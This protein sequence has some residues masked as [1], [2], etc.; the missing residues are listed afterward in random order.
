MNIEF[1]SLD[2]A[3]GTTAFPWLN[4]GSDSR[5]ICESLAASGVLTAPGDCFSA[6][7]HFRIGFARQAEGFG[8]ALAIA[9]AVLQRGQ[10]SDEPPSHA[11]AVLPER[12]QSAATRC[13]K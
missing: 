13:A 8:D 7:N 6:P 5:P 3:G 10:P 1:F 4:D 9:S 12:E 2:Q 11:Q